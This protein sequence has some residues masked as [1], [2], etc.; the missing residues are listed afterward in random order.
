MRRFYLRL[1]NRSDG[2]IAT[3]S[4]SYEDEFEGELQVTNFV[5]EF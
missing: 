1:S 5:Y 4:R 3:G 2:Y